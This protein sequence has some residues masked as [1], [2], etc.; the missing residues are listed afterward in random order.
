[1]TQG[2][3]SKIASSPYYVLCIWSSQTN[4]TSEKKVIL[5]LLPFL[6]ILSRAINCDMMIHIILVAV[7]IAAIT[8]SIVRLSPERSMG[9]TRTCKDFAL[10]HSPI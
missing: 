3:H 6:S 8:P 1:M 2:I 10:T 4:L 9:R 7:V 5:A